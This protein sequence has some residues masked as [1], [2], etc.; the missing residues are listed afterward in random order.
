MR[1]PS[2]KPVESATRLGFVHFHTEPALAHVYLHEALFE[3]RH[4][5]EHLAHRR[6]RA[7]DI[8]L[9]AEIRHGNVDMRVAVMCHG[10]DVSRP[11]PRGLQN[12][13]GGWQSP[14]PPSKHGLNPCGAQAAK[15][16]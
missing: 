9:D 16:F 5:W 10:G 7:G 14:A 8:L 6:G 12:D 15:G 3:F 13:F 4:G 11:L 2:L 1:A